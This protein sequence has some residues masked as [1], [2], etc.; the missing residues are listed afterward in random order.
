MSTYVKSS[1]FP[2]SRTKSSTLNETKLPI[3]KPEQNED[4]AID[5]TADFKKRQ[6]R[7]FCKRE[8]TSNYFFD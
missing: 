2:R 1:N 4:F 7:R 3:L 8:E 6:N 5:K